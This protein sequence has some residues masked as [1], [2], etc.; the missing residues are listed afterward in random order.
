MKKK[1]HMAENLSSE[2]DREPRTYT[3]ESDRNAADEPVA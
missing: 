3:R 2:P 1:E